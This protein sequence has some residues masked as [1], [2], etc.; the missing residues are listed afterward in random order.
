MSVCVDIKL[1]IYNKY[2]AH[3]QWT[4]LLSQH[5]YAINRVTIDFTALLMWSLTQQQHAHIYSAFE[6]REEN[7]TT[8][9]NTYLSQQSFPNRCI[10][11]AIHNRAYCVNLIKLSS[12]SYC[13]SDTNHISLTNMFVWS[14]DSV[15][16]QEHRQ[17]NSHLRT[18]GSIFIHNY[19]YKAIP[20]SDCIAQYWGH[21]SPSDSESW[22]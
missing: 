6:G 9:V 15:L 16:S 5:L 19:P 13:Q 7:S 21:I 20:S 3:Y 1:I 11:V 17:L 18:E 10:Q 12:L 22:E 4:I 8:V 2:I 14:D